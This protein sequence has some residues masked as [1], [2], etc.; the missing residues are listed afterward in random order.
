MQHVIP[1]LYH[2]RALRH[3]HVVAEAL[4]EV[5]T[6][7]GVPR[8]ILTDQGA[9]FTSGVMKEVHVSRLLSMK[10]LTTTCMPYVYHPACN[11]LVERFNGSLKQMLKRLCAERPKDWDMP[12]LI[13]VPRNTTCLIRRLSGLWGISLSG[14]VNVI[15]RNGFKQQF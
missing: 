4:I 1:R 3:I 7:V 6:R 12:T 2:S 15:M 5:F 8:E 14:E 11:G 13:C 10:Q 9:Q